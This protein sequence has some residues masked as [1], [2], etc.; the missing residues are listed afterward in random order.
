MKRIWLFSI[1]GLA[2][3]G[4]LRAGDLTVFPFFQELS[5]PALS[6]NQVGAFVLDHAVYDATVELS[7]GLRIFDQDGNEVPCWVRKKTATRTV[8]QERP[9]PAEI[10]TLKESADNR[11]EI[12]AKRDTNNPPPDIIKFDTQGRNFEKQ[13]TV[14]GSADGV[15]WE[16]LTSNAP[17][18][19]YSRYLDV[20]NDR[21]SVTSRNYEHYKIE[22]ANIAETRDSPLT[23][24]KKHSREDRELD[25][26]ETKV[27]HREALRLERITFVALKELFLTG[28]TDTRESAVTN[29]SLQQDTRQK[30]TM[31]TF[32]TAC[33]PVSAIELDVADPN[34]SR[35][36]TVFG[37][38]SGTKTSWVEKAAGKINRIR[39]GRVQQEHLVMALPA[40]SRERHY[41]L[42]IANQDNPPLTIKG[43]RL[44]ENLYE[45]LFFTKADRRYRVF[46]GGKNQR[47]P[48]YDVATVLQAVPAGSADAWLPNEPKANP[49]FQQGYS[50]AWLSSKRLL[51]A[52]VIVMVAVLG[53][54]I[55]RA[56]GKLDQLERE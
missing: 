15:Y 31:L 12:L 56:T 8:Q 21:V 32:S 38:E 52:A 40:E 17:I 24:I 9:F 53:W 22:I 1:V 50:L 4:G 37:A 49:V 51:V 47:T 55:V 6:S 41:R 23:E 10:I 26:T 28:A 48:S 14:E 7:S 35:A 44:R 46:F 16:T 36:L 11:I 2:L 25:R 19:D 39:A 45:V 13:V 18:Y 29:W 42:A 30:Q 3:A 33:Q 20:R 43:I 5:P 27:W 54:V 34:F